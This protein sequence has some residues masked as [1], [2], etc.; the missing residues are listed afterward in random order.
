MSPDSNKPLKTLTLRHPY[1][2]V[3]P[4]S[5]Q[6]LRQR[7]ESCDELRTIKAGLVAQA[8]ALLE[9]EP[10]QPRFD[11]RHTM[12]GTS[13]RYLWSIRTLAGAYLL[14]DQE[15]Y[16][17]RAIRFMLTAA[18]FSTWN[19]SHFLDVAEMT[20]ALGI[21]YD[22]T[23]PCMSDDERDVIGGAIVE[24]GLGPYIDGCEQEVWWSVVEHNWN[25]V[26]HGGCG[27]GALAVA[28]EHRGVA[29]RALR[30]AIEHYPTAMASYG[31][32]GAC[33]E[34]PMY[35]QYAT[36]YIAAFF[37]CLESALGTDFGLSEAE[38]FSKTGEF[39]LHTTGPV[40]RSFNFADATSRVANAPAMFWLARRF[41]RPAYAGWE[42][43]R[44]DHDAHKDIATLLW[45]QQPPARAP[46]PLDAYFRGAEVVCLR[47]GWDGDALYVGFKGG[48]NKV[49]HGHLDLGSFVLDAHG[50]RWVADLGADAYSLPGWFGDL[51][52]TYFRA[53]TE[54]HNVVA[55]DGRNQD[56][57]AVARI[58]S[59]HSSPER[60]YAICD[61]GEAYADA[62]EGARRGVMMLN[63]AAVLVQDEVEAK[64]AAGEL[65]WSFITESEAELD[66]EG[67]VLSQ[68][69][70]RLEVKVLEPAGAAFEVL[71]TSPPPP[72]N[73][74]EGTR[75]LALRLPIPEGRR[76][77]RVAVLFRPAG[78]GAPEPEVIPLSEWAAA[79]S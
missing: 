16:A 70:K 42:W 57:E 24:T 3:T 35:W 60:A 50:V 75:K 2:L 51:R 68:G 32:D 38:G 74:N 46:R 8:D 4:D 29:E 33:G 23:Q 37:A 28:H 55:L 25:Q 1:L 49:N 61:L 10:P 43:E 30:F 62:A 78:R 31:P 72:Q 15:S 67:A 45:W 77:L 65:T 54:G 79:A 26:C 11:V 66:G 41:G 12:L 18:G 17:R 19:P 47:S 5:V 9:R 6:D 40:G 73:Q 59:F 14:T 13:R 53:N 21:G 20:H 58:E 69:G 44:W 39:R 64:D 36:G 71:S 34:G 63:R 27:I 7:V 76:A 56:P 22:W 52:W 48:D